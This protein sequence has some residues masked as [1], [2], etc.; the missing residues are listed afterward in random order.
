MNTVWFVIIAVVVALAMEPISGAIHRYVGHGVGW[1]LH[2]SHHETPVKGPE[3][4][5]V[6]PAVS[7]L[8][9]IALMVIGVYVPGYSALAAVATGATIYGGVYF[10]IHD[11][12]I[13]RRLPLLPQRIALLEPYKQAHLKHH[14]TGTDHWRIFSR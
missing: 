1:V 13:H 7:A 9:A 10:I 3:L 6:I 4:N 12:Y 8:V 5:D 2:R 14:D 11:I